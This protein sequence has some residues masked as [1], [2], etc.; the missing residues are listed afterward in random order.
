MIRFVY[1]GGQ[2]SLGKEDRSFAFYDTVNDSFLKF[3]FSHV[4][5]SI[6]ELKNQSKTTIERLPRKIEYLVDMAEKGLAA[7]EL[8][9]LEI[10]RKMIVPSEG[11]LVSER[12]RE[13]LEELH[14]TNAD[15]STLR[16]DLPL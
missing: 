12:V 8:D 15:L 14:E 5:D 11:Q 16:G 1:I 2:I 9:E 6:E 10:I 13:I 7:T 4:L 3:D